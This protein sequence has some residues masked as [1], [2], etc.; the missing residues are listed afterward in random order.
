MVNNFPSFS[1]EDISANEGQTAS[2]RGI[3]LNKEQMVEVIPPN[4]G[5][6]V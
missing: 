1:A 3:P 5:R 4:D 6:M 2:Y